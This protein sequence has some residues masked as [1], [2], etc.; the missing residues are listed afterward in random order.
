[1]T[2]PFAPSGVNERAPLRI[3]DVVVYGATASGVMASVAAAREGLKV[4]L[5]EPG[6]HVGGMV[7]GGLGWTDVGQR[8]VIGGMALDFYARVGQAYDTPAF[9]WAGPEPHVAERIFLEWLDAAGLEPFFGVRLEQVEKDEASIQTITMNNGERYAARV[10][11]DATY[12]GDLLARSGVSYAIGRESTRK[13]G[14]SWAGRQPWR[15]HKHNFDVYLSPFREGGEELLPLMH[16]RPMVPIGEGDG[17]VQGYGFRL[18]LTRDPQRRL[19]FPEPAGFEP[20]QFELMRRYLAQK[21]EQ[22]HA[23]QLMGLTPNLPNDKCDVNSIGP[24]SLNLLDGSN[25]AYPDAGYE[26]RQAIWDR[27]LHYAQ[28]LLYFLAHDPSVPAH[29][30]EELNTWGLC[31]D[32]FA[33]TDHWPHQ[34]Y[35]REARRMVGEYVMTQHDLDPG[36]RKYDSVGMGSYH[37]DIRS[38]QRVWDYV[39]LHPQLFPAVFNEGYISVPVLPYEIPYRSL[40]P[41]FY[42]CDNLLV[43]VCLSASHVAFAS[44]RMEPQYMILG[45]SAGIAASLAVREEIPVQQVSIASLQRRLAEQ[46]QVLSLRNA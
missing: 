12:E 32:E 13:H 46:H 25:W 4:A 44:I 33:D 29:I 2:A 22:V 11:I 19:P 10:F 8:Q 17:G 5:L 40:T 28:S 9:A 14:E 20:D 45:H 35:V 23:R 3:Y 18:C 31:Q 24:L 16:D 34:L 15:P 1:M 43:P 38:T 21:G 42:E 7:S 30:R 36:V 27:H 37:I 39:H 6:R 26:E 41:R